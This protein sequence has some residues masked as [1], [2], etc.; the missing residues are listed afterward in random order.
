MRPNMSGRSATIFRHEA[1][2]VM[3]SPITIVWFVVPFAMMAFVQHAFDIYLATTGHQ[4]STGAELVGPGVTA[5]Y[6]FLALSHLGLVTYNEHQWN[7]WNRLQSGSVT[8]SELIRGKVAFHL[9]FIGMLMIIQTLGAFLIWRVDLPNEFLGIAALL[10]L[11]TT[12]IVAWGWLGIALMPSNSLFDAWV[13]GGAIFM[14][15]IGG[16]IVPFGLLPAA[17]QPVARISPIYW[18]ID[19][20]RTL[21]I[22]RGTTEDIL[23]PI[24]ALAAFTVGFA[25]LAVLR[26]DPTTRRDGRQQ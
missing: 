26:F 7:V 3:M 24:L 25:A 15:A 5:L 13:Y 6:A 10:I 16:A 23:G 12:T 19:G 11:T 4:S 18:L 1:R 8:T 20:F 21:L 14:A 17:V 22:D 9:V 2:M